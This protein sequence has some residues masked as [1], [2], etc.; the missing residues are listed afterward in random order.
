MRPLVLVRGGGDLATG[1]AA[2]LVR[3]GLP[4]LVTEIAQ[5]L[6]VRRLVSFAEAVFAG[7]VMVEELKARRVDRLESTFEVL[8]QGIVPVLVDAD[9]K[10]ALSLGPLVLVD[11]RMR[12]A[13][14]ELGLEVA[15]MVIGLG[16]GF[17][18][19]E[20]C[21]A[22]VETNRGH[23]MGRVVWQGTT[24]ADTAVPEAVAGVDV[25]RVLRSPGQGPMR[26]LVQLGDM[27]SPGTPL[28]EVHSR[29][30]RAGFRGALRGLLHDG[31]PAYPGMKVGDLDPRAEPRYCREISDKSLAVGGGVLEA[32]LSQPAIRSR[33]LG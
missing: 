25:D 32:I 20:N 5:P 16:P 30:V 23:A 28:F 7:E 4:V 15:Q 26:G 17:V 29:I 10:A 22:A 2:R 21:H 13:P 1:V 33:L 12:K 6:A 24:Q 8:D 14:P 18:A 9:A 11:G 19:G 3:C 27:V 31:V